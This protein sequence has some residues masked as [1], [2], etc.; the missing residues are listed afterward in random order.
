[1]NRKRHWL[2][3][4]NRLHTQTEGGTMSN[5]RM[6]QSLIASILTVLMTL[7]ATAQQRRAAAP[8]GPAKPAAGTPDLQRLS[9]IIARIGATGGLGGV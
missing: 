2:E 3:K 9:Q 1:M 7:P 5:Q 8:G 6:K 4:S